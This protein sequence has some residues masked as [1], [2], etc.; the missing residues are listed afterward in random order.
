MRFP[1]L[2]ECPVLNNLIKQAFGSTKSLINKRKDVMHRISSKTLTTKSIV[3]LMVAVALIV[4]GITGIQ[5]YLK[6]FGY[7]LTFEGEELGFI[8]K[9][10]KEEIENFIVLL[11]EEARNVYELDVMLN[12]TLDFDESRR[13]GEHLAA[14]Q[15]KDELRQRLSFNAFGYILTVSGKEIVA[16]GS[17]ED[18]NVVTQII[19]ETFID[20][21]NTIIKDISIQEDLT[22]ITRPV[23]PEEIIRVEEAVNILL[24][25][26]PQREVHLVSRGD[27]LWSISRAHNVSVLELQEANP[28]IVDGIIK[29][30]DELGLIISEPLVNVTLVEEVKV[31][32][33]IPYQTSYVNDSSLFTSQTRVQ[34]QGR[35]GE[36]VVTYLVTKENR[37][38]TAKEVLQETIIR[39]P[40]TEVVARG[41]SAAPNYGIGRFIWP[42]ASKGTI[43]SGF[44]PRWGKMHYGVDIASPAGTPIRA[45]DSGVVQTSSYQ[46]SWGNLIVL[47]H[48]NGYSTYYA[49]NS[50]LLVKVGERVEQGQ[51]IALVGSTGYSTGNHVHFEIRKKGSPLNPLEFFSFYK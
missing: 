10:D 3:A 26:I 13:S 25:G 19:K 30:N 2:R 7:V 32:E 15:M 48:G 44:G 1:Q 23:A 45:A 20:K 24:T 5:G 22:Y 16:L 35:I 28:Q 34:T 42:L 47:D 50:R 11:T 36:K 17:E 38:V 46:G 8:S 31:T 37:I 9:S 33:K 6:S 51:T 43:T 49:H 27:S 21:E 39:E 18:Y 40:V 41:T 14:E 12:G 4:M 29:P